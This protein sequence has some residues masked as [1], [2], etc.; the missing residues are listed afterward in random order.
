MKEIKVSIVCI[1]YNHA[2]YIRDALEG[3]LN[4]RV[5]FAYEIV[6]HDDA[7]TDETATIIRKY[8]KKYP[9]LIRGIYQKENQYLKCDNIF[10]RYIIPVCRGKYVALCEGDDCWVDHNKLQIQIT[11]ME[12][13]PECF[14]TA[15]SAV[16]YDATEKSIKQQLPFLEEKNL[17][18]EEIIMKYHGNLPTASMIFRKEI[19][20]ADDF[21][22]K[23][24]VGDT[25][26]QMYAL[27][28]G[29]IHY[30]DRVM[31]LYR[32]NHNGSW[33]YEYLRNR[34]KRIVHAIRMTH[35]FSQY[36]IYTKGKYHEI[37]EWKKNSYIDEAVQ[38]GYDMLESSFMELCTDIK[39]ENEEYFS[40]YIRI[41]EEFYKQIH[42]KDYI[43]KEIKDFVKG[44]EEL[45]IIGAGDYG[46]RLAGQLKKNQ[47]PFAG[48]VLSDE[49][50]ERF[51]KVAIVDKRLKKISEMKDCG[52][53][54]RLIGAV[55]PALWIEIEKELRKYIKRDIYRYLFSA[56]EAIE[57]MGEA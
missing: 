18:A 55:N 49:Q 51:D 1:A 7:S 26:M 3:F 15:H 44:C 24:G 39:E 19:C 54:I 9:G 47:I 27:A 8:E 17:T 43:R 52:D 11:Y 37:V 45:W 6:V 34:K 25:P 2:D 14:L 46:R 38:S 10:H 29:E 30:F 50:F 28:K 35:F 41:I 16:I 31:S 40:T 57:D 13:H 22:W 48:F 36:D 23:S 21:F 33:D 4:Q 12:K 56:T 42:C 20:N 5:D 32:F 53:G